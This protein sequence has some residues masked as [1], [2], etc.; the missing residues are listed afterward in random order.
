MNV[1]HCNCAETSV[2]DGIAKYL[3]IDIVNKTNGEY[4]RP[5]FPDSCT[6]R[7]GESKYLIACHNHHAWNE[8]NENASSSTTIL[9]IIAVVCCLILLAVVIILYRKIKN[10]EGKPSNQSIENEVGIERP[11]QS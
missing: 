9:L 4:L 6:Q 1:G 5:L 8:C 7:N 10:S 11:S 3:E 2:E